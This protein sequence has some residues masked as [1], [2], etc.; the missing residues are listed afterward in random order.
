MG[1]VGF[2]DFWVAGTRVVF[3][4]DDAGATKYPW[5]DLGLIKQAQPAFAVE[6]IQLEDPDGGV[7]KIVDEKVTKNDETYD[8]T[9]ANFN[10][11]N[12]ALAF[13]ANPPST[14]TQTVDTLKTVTTYVFPESLI[15]LVDSDAAG[16][17]LYGIKVVS[18]LFKGTMSTKPTPGSGTVISASAKTIV[19]SGDQTAVAGLAVGKSFFVQ[20]T[21]LVNKLNAQSYTVVSSVFA[22]NTTITVAETPAADETGVTLT[23]SHG[24]GTSS[25][26][27]YKPGVDWS[28]V[29]LARGLVR[30]LTGGAITPE[31]NISIQFLLAGLSGNRLVLPQTISGNV[32][33][34]AV[35]YFGRDN[36][37]SDSAREARVSLSTTNLNMTA[38]D[39]SDF[40][41]QAKVLSSITVAGAGRLL[42]IA[43]TLPASV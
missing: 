22:T 14:F 27:V 26:I 13:Y 21:N 25:N 41:L 17:L 36:F 33:G 1:A 32:K 24:D 37:S 12:L 8:L 18:A 34:L 31:G 29:S 15:K 43:G 16:T 10:P 39:Y 23:I 20:P 40:V 5:L 3:K 28:V 35:V 9:I 38:D 6:K 4:R 2:Q 30:S 11:D 7:K 19:L 42:S